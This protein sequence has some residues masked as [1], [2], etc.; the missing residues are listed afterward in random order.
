[1]DASNIKRSLLVLSLLLGVWTANVQAY[2]RLRISEDR[3]LSSDEVFTNSLTLHGITDLSCSKQKS[4][5]TSPYKI[6]SISCSD[7]EVTFEVTGHEKSQSVASAFMNGVNGFLCSYGTCA[8]NGP[9]QLNFYADLNIKF[10]VDGTEY[11]VENFRIGQSTRE[12]EYTGAT[13]RYYWAASKH[14]SRVSESLRCSIEGEDGKEW[15][16]DKVNEEHLFS[17]SI[18]SVSS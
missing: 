18:M 6:K 5:I 7:N 2:E 16:V 1:M 12:N 10:K 4:K 3:V 13:V 15:K 14:C 9:N 17:T 11:K 8:H